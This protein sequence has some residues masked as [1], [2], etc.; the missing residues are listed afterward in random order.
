MHFSASAW[1][2]IA[3][4]VAAA[5][6]YGLA[7][8]SKPPSMLRAV[9][10]TVF[11]AALAGGL[12][13]AGAPTIFVIALAAAAL[14]DFFLA[15]DKPLVLPLG[16]VA[17]L[18]MQALYIA[19]FLGLIPDASTDIWPRY[20]MAA[21]VVAIVVAYLIW[22]WREARP[23]K[24]P[25]LALLAILGAFAI[26]G[27]PLVI[28]AT[29]YVEIDGPNAYNVH[30]NAPLAGFVLAASIVCIWLR[31]DLGVIKLVGMIYAAVILQMVFTSFWLPWAGWTVMLGA[32]SF[33]LSDGVL[34]AELF[35]L[36]PDARAR[37]ITGPVVWWTYAA[38]QLLI[39]FGV[40]QLT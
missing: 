28:A 3:L 9:V 8:E 7:F 15:F 29:G 22:F 30:P 27:F 2:L 16:M 39:A 21:T 19:T 13:L 33:L 14:G 35:R 6:V 23:G 10:K 17:F 34:S 5:A 1:G 18:I 37:R 31:R 12:K 26:G 11:L 4:S 25:L 40:V 32:L 36:Q 20:A 24:N 38:A